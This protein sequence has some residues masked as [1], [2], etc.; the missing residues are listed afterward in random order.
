MGGKIGVQVEFTGVTAEIASKPELVTLV[1]EIAMQIA[2]SSPSYV[3]RAAVPADVLEKEKSIY[4]AQMENSGKPANVIDK[5]VE[6]KLGSFYSQVV[7][8]DQASIR[9]PKMTVAEVITA[10]SKSLGATLTVSRF[11]RLRVGEGAQ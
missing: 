9:D 10:A 7:L 6:G 1:K 5:I 8:P 4:R 2:A 11:A 3:S